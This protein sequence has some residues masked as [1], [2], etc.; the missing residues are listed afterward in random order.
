[1]SQFLL[2]IRPNPLLTDPAALD[3]LQLPTCKPVVSD[4]HLSTQQIDLIT[5]VPPVATTQ[6]LAAA[7][8]EAPSPA[9]G[10]RMPAHPTQLEP[11]T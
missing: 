10:S 4:R 9:G 5:V 1:M 3:L 7:P 6:Q 2:R 11:P 8:E